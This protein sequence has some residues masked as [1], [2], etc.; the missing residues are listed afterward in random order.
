MKKWEKHKTKDY[1]CHGMLF[2]SLSGGVFSRTFFPFQC[3]AHAHPGILSC[4]FWRVWSPLGQV[5]IIH[6]DIC[7]LVLFPSIPIL[8][9][10]RHLRTWKT[11]PSSRDTDRSTRVYRLCTHLIFFSLTPDLG[12]S[13][14]KHLFSSHRLSFISQEDAFDH[15]PHLPGFIGASGL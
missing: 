1:L 3:P 6:L 5:H 7:P 11:T 8:V 4:L 13:L 15:P 9:L 12:I 10:I 14:E 2:L